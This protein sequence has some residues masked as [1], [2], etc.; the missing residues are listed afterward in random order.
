MPSIQEI[1]A[2]KK[3]K[4]QGIEPVAPK[5]T[6]VVD[7]EVK[8]VVQTSAPVS[9]AVKQEEPAVVPKKPLSFQEM[10]ALKKAAAEASKEV[11]KSSTAEDKITQDE[12]AQAVSPLADAPAP[13]PAK[14]DIGTP[15]PSIAQHVDAEAALRTGVT[16]AA[17]DP[18]MPTVSDV[19]DVT[20][21]AHQDIVN[22]IRI[23]NE[24]SGDDLVNAMKELK[25]ALMKNPAAVSLMED[26]DIGQMVIALRKITGEAVIEAAKDKTPGRKKAPKMIDLSDPTAVAGVLDEL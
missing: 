6:D 25:A 17:L 18:N 19:D 1:L 15:I 16:Q 24:K 21:Q 11:L 5:A 8:E 10:M 26:S 22:K 4:E 2:A 13:T 14:A 9:E 20:L 23:L 3:A 7:V 12:P